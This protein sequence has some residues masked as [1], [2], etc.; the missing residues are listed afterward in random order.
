MSDAPLRPLL[1]RFRRGN[2]DQL[3]RDAR[4]CEWDA[5]TAAAR[6]YRPHDPRHARRRHRP[7][8][9]YPVA[10]PSSR[11]AADQHELNFAAG[12]RLAGPAPDL[13]RSRW[14]HRLMVAGAAVLCVTAVDAAIGIHVARVR[15]GGIRFTVAWP[16]MRYL[17]YAAW[18]VP[19]GE[20]A[21]LTAGQVFYRH[22]FRAAQP[23]KFRHLIIQVTTTGREEQRVNEV[24]NQIRS[25]RLQ[26]SHE[27]WVVTQ[28]GHGDRRS[29]GFASSMTTTSSTQC[30]GAAAIAVLQCPGS[31]AP[32]SPLNAYM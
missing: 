10:I 5:K 3:L 4:F 27:I 13:R 26:M 21:M 23:G 29:L 30:L 7:L 25:Y 14:W 11:P 1:I 31:P 17:V 19:L 18:L 6:A 20:L 12:D 22:R 32:V 24:I 28:P 8:S 9:A 15:V 2:P 16:C